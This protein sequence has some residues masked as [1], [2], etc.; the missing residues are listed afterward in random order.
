MPDA[1]S[2]R[3]FVAERGKDTRCPE[4]G[5]IHPKELYAYK[6]RRALREIHEMQARLADAVTYIPRAS[7]LAKAEVMG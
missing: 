5:K 7:T 6:Y 3:T 2:W 4:C 1:R